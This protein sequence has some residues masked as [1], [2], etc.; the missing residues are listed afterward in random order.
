MS[1]HGLTRRGHKS[2]VIVL[3]S[4]IGLLVYA[5]WH[6]FLQAFLGPRL[7]PLYEKVRAKEQSLLHYK[8]Y[9]H[10]NVKYFFAANHAHSKK[11]RDATIRALLAHPSSFSRL[12]LGERHARLHHDGFAR[13]RHQ[14]IVSVSHC[15]LS[16]LH[17]FATT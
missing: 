1:S 15:C 16:L 14:S 8:E 6:D 13:P 2:L 10:K 7:P 11:L 3:L 4:F 5:R 12:G 17:Y 9:E